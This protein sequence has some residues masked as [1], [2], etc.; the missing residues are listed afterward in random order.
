VVQ[1]NTAAQ[2]GSKYGAKPPTCSGKITPSVM[3]Q[4]FGQNENFGLNA[5]ISG[6]MA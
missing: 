6:R 5:Q 2:G 4:A 3:Q 1:I